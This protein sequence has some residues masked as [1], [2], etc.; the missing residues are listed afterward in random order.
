MNVNEIFIGILRAQL[1]G[2]E[3]SED[4]RSSVT[5][6]LLGELYSVSKHHDSAHLVGELLNRCG[7]LPD[8]SEYAEA[9]R[10]EFMLAGVRNMRMRHELSAI[11]SLFEKEKIPCNFRANKL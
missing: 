4:L 8:E 11:V 2:T 10:R 7:L 5:P 3:V 9:L 6:E 1:T